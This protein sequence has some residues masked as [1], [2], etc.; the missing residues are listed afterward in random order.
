VSAA[1]EKTLYAVLTVE[2]HRI[3]GHYRGLADQRD[4]LIEGELA[5]VAVGE[6]GDDVG[7]R[8]RTLSNGEAAP[9]RSLNQVRTLSFSLAAYPSDAYRFRFLWGI[10]K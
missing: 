7:G 4:R 10:P 5:G 1:A 2:G 8:R 9:S 3:I 6:R